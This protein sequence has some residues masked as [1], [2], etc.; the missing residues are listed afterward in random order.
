MD[1]GRAILRDYIEAT[2]GF[3]QFGAETG[4]SPRSL[5]RM[6]GP[7]D[8]PRARNRLTVVSHLQRHAGLTL[9]ITALSHRQLLVA[10]AGPTDLLAD[11]GNDLQ[12]RRA[13]LLA[14]FV[15]GDV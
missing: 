14:R 11:G 3:K 1:I 12:G 15:V 4:C 10:L 7:T 5:I 8:N 2:V 9:H 6:I 13:D